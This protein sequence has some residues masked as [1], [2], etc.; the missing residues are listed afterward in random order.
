MKYHEVWLNVNCNVVVD[1][2]QPAHSLCSLS[3]SFDFIGYAGDTRQVRRPS[4]MGSHLTI[5]YYEDSSCF[6]ANHILACSWCYSGL[7][8]AP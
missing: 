5:T 4:A 8:S 3:A 2:K 1:P 6:K 7:C